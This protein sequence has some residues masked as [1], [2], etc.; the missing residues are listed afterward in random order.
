M[1]S[2]EGK[3][4][5]SSHFVCSKVAKS[6]RWGMPFSFDETVLVTGCLYIFQQRK[7][8]QKQEHPAN[9]NNSI[10]WGD[11]INNCYNNADRKTTAMSTTK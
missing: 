7:N 6:Q 1:S 5:L 3:C 9:A 8:F 11:T 10:P 2:L 4:V